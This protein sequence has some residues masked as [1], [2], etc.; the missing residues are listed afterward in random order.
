MFVNKFLVCLLSLSYMYKAIEQ[1]IY[2]EMWPFARL[3]VTIQTKCGF[4]Q[5]VLPVTSRSSPN[6]ESRRKLNFLKIVRDAL[7]VLSHLFIQLLWRKGTHKKKKG[8]IPE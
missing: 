2:R 7:F 4:S 1:E 3:G 8:K 5:L 6:G